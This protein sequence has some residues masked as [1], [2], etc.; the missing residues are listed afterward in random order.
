[1][2]EFFRGWKRK[3]GVITLLVACLFMG[4]WVRSCYVTDTIDVARARSF[5][6]FDAREGKLSIAEFQYSDGQ[7]RG[8]YGPIV[9][10]TNVV[11][12]K[13]KHQLYAPDRP[14]ATGRKQFPILPNNQV[15]VDYVEC[16]SWSITIP[17]T[18]LS[19]WLLLGKP[20]AKP[21][22]LTQS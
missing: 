14:L 8:N 11:D 19:A 13:A 22:G 20:R 5:Y 6:R 18:L 9:W 7:I 3:I 2:C 17:L 16:S 12:E 15:V 21:P 4:G 1:M 10:Q